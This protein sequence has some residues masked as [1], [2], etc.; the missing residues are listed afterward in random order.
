MKEYPEVHQHGII[1]IENKDMILG[2][3]LDFNQGIV[4][5]F[6]I[7]I[8]ED[9]RVWVC[10]N[11]IS[12]IRFKPIPKEKEKEKKEQCQYCYHWGENLGLRWIQFKGGH[13]YRMCK[14]CRTYTKGHWKYRKDLEE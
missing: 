12:F 2:R 5:D 7:Q 9:G 3:S 1:S 14:V 13:A 6:G 4:G 10:V 8:A 11:G